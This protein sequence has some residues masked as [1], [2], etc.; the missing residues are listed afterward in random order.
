MIPKGT[1]VKIKTARHPDVRAGTVGI[2]DCTLENGYGVQI[3][4]AWQV[5]GS[6]RGALVKET[7][8]VWFSAL[9]VEVIRNGC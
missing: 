5:A 8:V 7:R 4:G 1:T 2:V 6:D 9:H 3:D